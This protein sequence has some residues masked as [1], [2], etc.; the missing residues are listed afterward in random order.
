MKNEKIKIMV[1]RPQARLGLAPQRR[2]GAQPPKA[3]LSAEMRNRRRRLLARR[4]SAAAP[5]K[6]QIPCR[7]G[8]VCRGRMHAA[9]KLCD[10]ARCRGR[11]MFILHGRAGVHARRTR[12]PY[13]NVFWFV[14]AMP[15]VCRGGI[16][17]ARQGY[18]VTWG[19][20][21]NRPF[22]PVCRAGS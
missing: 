7:F 22:P 3:A 17:A 4:G 14:Y 19:S 18:A 6:K 11:V 5:R 1:L 13:N 9:C 20:R 16:H 8:V 10:I 15:G 21:K 12:L 2:F